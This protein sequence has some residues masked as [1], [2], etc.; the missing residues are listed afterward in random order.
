MTISSQKTSQKKILQINKYLHPDRGGIENVSEQ[1]SRIS[2]NWKKFTNICF[3]KSG[4]K[5]LK[6]KDILRFDSFELFSQ[7]ISLKYFFYIL[8]NAKNYDQIILHYPNVIGAFALLLA[9]TNAKIFLYWHSDIVKQNILLK[10]IAN[11]IE[12]LLIKKSYKVIFA[13]NA[14]KKYS[15]QNF[16]SIDTSI[17]PFTILN[18]DIATATYNKRLTSIKANETVEMLFI[19]RLVEYKGL[20]VL[21]DV[22]QNI[23]SKYKLSIVG[24]GPLSGYVSKKIENMENVSLHKNISDEELEIYFTESDLLVLPS[25]NKSEMFGI[26]Q[27]ESF[28]RGL[29]VISSNIEGSGVGL[30][31]KNEVSG[32]H[33]L[34]KNH[35]SLENCINSIDNAR[36]KFPIT[37]IRKYYEDNFSTKK[38]NDSI[39]EI[40]NES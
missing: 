14:H 16:D 37:S 10:I 22:M 18:E 8:K 5:Y 20:R 2:T 30:V 36:E 34:P 28:A 35:A 32:L 17:V 15:N 33:C 3:A 21:L 26:V 13:T 9:K 40:F 23:S 7:P 19:G 39:L 11:A 6:R 29:P 25:I 1:L 31:N 38:Y 12:R 4:S 24:N 27:I